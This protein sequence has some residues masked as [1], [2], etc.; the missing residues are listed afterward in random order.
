MKSWK[1]DTLGI[2]G[3]CCVVGGLWCFNDA[4]AIITA[5]VLLLILAIAGAIHAN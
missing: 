1:I 3:F 5:G 4:V 2:V